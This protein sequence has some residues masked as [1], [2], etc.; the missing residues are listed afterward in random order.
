LISEKSF[1]LDPSAF[2][3]LAKATYRVVFSH[4]LKPE[5]EPNS[6]D[7]LFFLIGSQD[8]YRFCPKEEWWSDFAHRRPHFLP[9]DLL[10]LSN[11]KVHQDGI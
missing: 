10:T 11:R 1:T 9:N 8:S 2:G 6:Q 4:A 5:F 7:D 3:G